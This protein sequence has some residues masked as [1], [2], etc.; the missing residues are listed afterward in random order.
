MT[1]LLRFMS[2]LVAAAV[3]A[4]AGHAQSKEALDAAARLVVSSGLAVQLKGLA[5]QIDAEVGH[6]RGKLPDEMRAALAEAARE[7]FRAAVLQDEIV[8]TV[9]QKMNPAEMRKA[10]DWL[11]T[12][13]GRRVTRA[14]ELAAAMTPT[15]TQAWVERVKRQPLT[16]KRTKLIVDLV[17][18]TK[19][20]EAMA[21]VTESMVLGVAVGMNAIQPVQQQI[22]PAELRKRMRA[23]MPPA[24][25]RDIA[26]EALPM[27][28]GYTY[29]D[30]G[31]AD[32]AS[33]LAFNRSPLG[34]RYNDVVMAA[35]IEALTHASVR[36]GQLVEP[37]LRRKS[38]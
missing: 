2:A 4:P 37:A 7:S 21:N 30:I 16:E 23:A 28:F 9:A 13:V 20:A 12:D 8:R 35:F 17:K 11:E 38:T 14:E 5:G 26:N 31:D 18:A 3:F 34:V 15:D 36:V 29:R 25:L 1:Q 19:A 27:L 6:T 10:A 32:L 33:Y 22:A 24:K